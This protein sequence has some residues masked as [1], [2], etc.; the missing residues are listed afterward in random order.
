MVRNPRRRDSKSV[1][2]LA[3]V[4]LLFGALPL[5]TTNVLAQDA[6]RFSVSRE[7]G[8]AEAPLPVRNDVARGGEELLIL[9]HQKLVKG[10]HHAFYRASRDGV[11]PWF[12]KI[13]TRIVGQ[14]Q[15]IHPD[16]EGG[17]EEHDEGYR[18]ARYRSYEHWVET[19][20]GQNLGGNGPD[21]QKSRASLRE[22]SQFLLGSDAAYFLEG[23]MAPGGPYYLPGLGESYEPADRDSKSDAADAPRPVRNSS[24]LAG[25]EIVAMRFW[26]I[27]KGTFDE[28]F[29][30]SVQGVWPYFEKIGARVIGQWKVVHP[31]ASESE[32][33]PDYDEVIMMTRYASYDHWKATRRGVE[34]GGNGPD[35]E[36]MR[37]AIALRR[38]LSLETSVI[39][40]QGNMY[41]SPPVYL[42]GL[43]ESYR[44]AED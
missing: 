27:K 20:Q 25:V 33:S 5:G 4:A 14:W 35:Y 37:E 39:F 16:G 41:H 15:V 23:H 21:L 32:E 28:F 13:G 44:R 30:A 1:I 26:K 17:N 7:R 31:P 22:R 19:R 29:E 12:E 9:R 43:G 18:L 34:L 40:L 6:G 2:A 36:A 8:S 24:A 3:L 38:S 11:W 10:S 42:P